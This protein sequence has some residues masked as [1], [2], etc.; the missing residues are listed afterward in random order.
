M[1][2]QALLTVLFLLSYALCAIS[3]GSSEIDKYLQLVAENRLVEDPIERDTLVLWNYAS[4]CE[5]M[6]RVQDPRTLA[7]LDTLTKMSLASNW[8]TARGFYLS[9]IHI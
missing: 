4:I 6:A 1:H 2:N 7:Y 9:L 5:E 8:P 3:Q